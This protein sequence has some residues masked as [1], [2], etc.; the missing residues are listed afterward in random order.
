MELHK[1]HVQLRAP[2]VLKTWKICRG[3]LIMEKQDKHIQS[4][5]GVKSTEIRCN[6][7][8]WSIL[9]FPVLSIVLSVTCFMRHFLT[10]PRAKKGL[11]IQKIGNL[12]M[13][14]VHGVLKQNY[15]P[16]SSVCPALFPFTS[17]HP[18]T[19]TLSPMQARKALPLHP[20]FSWLQPSISCFCAISTFQLK[21]LTSSVFQS[22]LPL[23]M[24]KAKD[25]SLLLIP[26]T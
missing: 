21:L 11:L 15:F 20:S 8:T 25:N 7:K 10:Y 6:R 16:N 4:T 3:M 1:D 26:N 17:I 14:L 2:A 13:R 22:S 18:S 5:Q 23:L 12:D 9:S 24:L 19:P